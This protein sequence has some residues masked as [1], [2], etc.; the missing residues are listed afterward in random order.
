M[1]TFVAASRL[2]AIN[3]ACNGRGGRSFHSPDPGDP[4]NGISGSGQDGH[5]AQGAV[6]GTQAEGNQINVNTG[7]C[8]LVPAIQK[9][10]NLWQNQPRRYTMS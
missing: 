10:A 6:T 2:R 4:R 3:W 5:Y 8:S 9:A 7:K 1:K